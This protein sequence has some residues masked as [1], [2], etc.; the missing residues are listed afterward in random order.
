[1]AYLCFLEISINTWITVFVDSVEICDRRANQVL[2]KA[3]I[4]SAKL[5]NNSLGM[6]KEA[7]VKPREI[8]SRR[9]GDSVGVSAKLNPYRIAEAD[10]N[11]SQS[12]STTIVRT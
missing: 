7:S 6:S 11:G 2:D 8:I 5:S 4:L 3:N 1:V 10:K 9:L 12:V